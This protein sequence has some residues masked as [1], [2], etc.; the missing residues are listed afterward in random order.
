MARRRDTDALRAFVASRRPDAA[1][2]RMGSW[3]RITIVTPSFNQGRYLE[4]T[5]LS[6]LNQ[7][8]PNLGYV[9]M[10]GGSTDGSVDIIQRYAS[11]LTFW[12]TGP[13]GGQ[14]DAIAR[15]FSLDD[16]EICGWVNSDDLLLPGALEFVATHFMRNP[17]VAFI[18]GDCWIIDSEQRVYRR[19]RPVEFDSEIFRFENSIIPQPASFWRRRAYADVGGLNS[20]YVYCMDYD[21]WSRLV[22]AGVRPVRVDRA[23]AAMRVHPDTKTARLGEVR[24]REYREITERTL[25]RRLGL[26]DRVRTPGLRLKRYWLEPRSFVEG[27][28]GR[29]LAWLRPPT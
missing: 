18:Y 19:V 9:V 4:Q 20:A 8:Y 7:N 11:E 12:T 15:G 1:R 13:D 10:D 24:R 6:V 5:I 16:G 29:I 27:C 2:M 22:Q 14:A 25:G 21:F 28:A 3:P 17:E 26:R 23:L